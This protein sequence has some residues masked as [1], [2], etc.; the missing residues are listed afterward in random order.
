MQTRGLAMQYTI[1]FERATLDFDKSRSDKVLR[2]DDESGTRFEKF[3]EE[4]GYVGQARCFVECIQ[5]KRAPSVVTAAD[6]V[7]AVEICAAEELSIRT[8]QPV[9]L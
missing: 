2:I 9:E 3:D 6:G 4:E 1:N 5:K 7:A 8:R